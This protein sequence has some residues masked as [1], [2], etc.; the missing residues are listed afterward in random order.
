MVQSS[1]SPAVSAPTIPAAVVPSQPAAPS[2]EAPAAADAT[3]PVAAPPEFGPEIDISLAQSLDIDPDDETCE[4]VSA[5]AVESWEPDRPDNTP[6]PAPMPGL[7]LTSGS[8]EAVSGRP[9]SGQAPEP[10]SPAVRAPSIAR[11]RNTSL[12]TFPFALSGRLSRTWT[13]RGAL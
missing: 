10:A 1:A 5:A 8:H 13:R 9:A 4:P 12:R 2:A 3:V 11:A 7:S 6:L